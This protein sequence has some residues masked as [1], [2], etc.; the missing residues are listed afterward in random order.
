MIGFILSAMLSAAAAGAQASPIPAPAAPAPVQSA[1]P[2]ERPW[3]GRGGGRFAL[4]LSPMGE[5]FRGQASR[6]AGL[7]AWF[8]QADTDHNGW[9]SVQE[10]DD[11]ASRFFATLDSAKDGEIDPDDIDRYENQLVPEIH[12]MD[13]GFRDSG[14][15][16]APRGD[17]GGGHRGGG[18]G[19]RGG[20]RGGG[21]GDSEDSGG[22]QQ[23]STIVQRPDVGLK[24]AGRFGLLNTPEPVTSADSDFNRGVSDAEFRKSATSRFVLLDTNRDGKLTLDELQP[25]LP[26]AGGGR[27]N[28]N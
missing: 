20:H 19:G 25:R 24:G 18:G 9:L 11:D 28:G 21:G 15:G 1:D 4:F 3:A 23:G 7:Q 2:N 27:R 12:M 5:P 26:P 6:A 8:A 10:M 17:G 14:D 13:M 22:A 16:A